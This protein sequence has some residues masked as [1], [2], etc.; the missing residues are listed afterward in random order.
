VIGSDAWENQGW[1]RCPEIIARY[2]ARLAELPDDGANAIA[3]ADAETLFAHRRLPGVDPR[4]AL[5]SVAGRGM[6][7]GGGRS[8]DAECSGRSVRPRVAVG[9]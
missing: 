4:R 2:R 7:R 9:G 3:W 8:G 6:P 1:E 5:R